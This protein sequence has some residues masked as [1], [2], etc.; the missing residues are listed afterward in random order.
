MLRLGSLLGVLAMLLGAAVALPAMAQSEAEILGP[1]H[2]I[3]TPPG[4]TGVT[5]VLTI[6]KDSDG[7]LAAVFSQPYSG[8]NAG[9]PVSALAV[10]DGTLGFAIARANA[11]FEGKWDAAAHRWDGVFKVGG[12]DL[13]LRLEAGKP[14]SRP[15]VAGLDGVWQGSIERNGAK[16]RLV[17]RIATAD[18][19]TVAVLDSPDQLSYGQ[20]VPVLGRD[21][22]KVELR[23]P[24]TGAAYEARLSDD[25]ATMSGVWKRPGV[26]DAPVTFARAAGPVARFST[27]RPQTPRPPFDYRVEEVT[28]DNPFEKG[29]SLAGTLTLPKGK[30]PFPAAILISGSGANDRDDTTLGHKPFAVIADHLTRHGVAVLRYDDRGVGGSKGDHAAADSVDFATDANSAARYLAGRPEIRPDAIG[31]IGHSE[32]GVT[33]PLAMASN[34]HI[35]FLVMLA[36]PGVRWDQVVLSQWRQSGLDRGKTRQELDRTEPLVAAIYRAIGRAGGDEA[37]RKAVLPLLTPEAMAAMG[38]PPNTDRETLARQMSSRWARYL[39]GYDPAP[40]LRKIRVPVLAI[41]G[42]LDHQIPSDQNLPA[43]KAAL[44]HSPDATVEE[45]PGLNHMFQTAGTGAVGEY[46][47]IQETFA[48]AALDLV[49]DWLTRRF[50]RK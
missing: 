47:D 46:A 16:L 45:L 25:L 31:F 1:W 49:T 8:A 19:G 32:G 26:P 30:G 9:A 50:V 6:R 40:N 2:G 17:L 23:I 35:A 39:F 36:G 38:I 37:A 10:R 13:P 34:T 43:I 7:A 24:A 41:G 29:V 14:A 44:V 12:A 4:S 20:E 11:A 28:F 27:D 33:A 22:A 21:G 48:P 3:L 15:V 5:V 42:S 18:Y